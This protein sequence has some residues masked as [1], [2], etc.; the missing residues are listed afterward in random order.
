MVRREIL[1]VLRQT[2]R[3]KISEIRKASP[4]KIGFHAFHVNLYLHEFFE[5]ILFFDPHGLYSPWPKR[6]ILAVLRQTKKG[7]NLKN[8][9]GLIHQNWFPCISHQP[10]LV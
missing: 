6:E 3:S 4:T 10:L 7:Q 5:M 8:R 2:K 1:A 9:R